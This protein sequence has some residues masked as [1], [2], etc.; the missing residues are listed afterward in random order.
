MRSHSEVEI[1][2]VAAPPGVGVT[3]AQEAALPRKLLTSEQRAPGSP[4]EAEEQSL[5][6][7]EL[8]TEGKGLGASGEAETQTETED[9]RQD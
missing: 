1:T 7:Q 8:S 9:R 6:E 4:A 2:P 5:E 3:P